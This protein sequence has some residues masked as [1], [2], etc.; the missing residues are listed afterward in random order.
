M[1]I[2]F[3]AESIFEIGVQIEKNGR[4]FYLE[5]AENVSEESIKSL[6]TELADW[7]EE[8]IELFEK[9]KTELPDTMREDNLF[10]PENE[11]YAY[12]EAAANSHVFVASTNVSQLVAGCGSP[13]EI[14]DLA[15]RFEKDS[16]VYYTTMKKVVADH[17]GQG[18]IDKL[19]NEELQH[20]SIL[21]KKKKAV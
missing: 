1:S 4:A 16:V 20:I 8:H 7:E 3:N 13:A 12:L 2:Q 10:D 11:F 5:A 6:L 18:K 15:L 17:L 19:I 14:F 21:N 9:L